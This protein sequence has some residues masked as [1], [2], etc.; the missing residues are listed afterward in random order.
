MTSWHVRSAYGYLAIA[1]QHRF[2]G[3]VI[4]G[5]GVFA[6]AIVNT[7]A[8]GFAI[9]AG[10]VGQ[11]STSVAYSNFIASALVVLGMHL[12]IFEDLIEELRHAASEI[13]KSRDDMRAAANTDPLTGCYNRRFL[14]EIA[15]HELEHHRRYNLPLSLLYIDIDHFKAINDARGHLTGDEVLKTLGV[16]LRELTRQADYVFRWGGDEFI[17]LLSATEA[18]ATNKAGRIRQAFLE[19]A[20]VT[21][22]PDGIDLSIGCVQVPPET[23]DFDPLIDQ[24]DKEMYRRKRALAG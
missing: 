14:Y 8:V 16:I 7:F 20:I 11:A 19:S 15:D 3:A 24:A 6:I 22:L 2:V 17:V 10:G 13:A 1:R 18:E 4:S 21:R 23:R 12:L 5:I 9:A